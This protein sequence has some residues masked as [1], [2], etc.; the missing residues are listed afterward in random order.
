MQRPRSWHPSPLQVYLRAFSSS[1]IPVFIWV[2]HGENELVQHQ[3]GTC[4]VDV[5]H[6]VESQCEH[7]WMTS[8]LPRFSRVTEIDPPPVLIA[9][10]RPHLVVTS[11][12]DTSDVPVLCQ[13]NIDGRVSLMTLVVSAR[14]PPVSVSEIFALAIPQHDC[15][16]A[17]ECYILWGTS[18]L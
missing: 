13:S 7:H 12:F 1:R 8:G 6:D 5:R 10:P 15:E 9:V 18:A 14:Y 11:S 16:H 3:S 2:H 17:S 4:S